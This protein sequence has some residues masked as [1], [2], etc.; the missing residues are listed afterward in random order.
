VSSTIPQPVVAQLTR[1]AIFLVVTIKPE[2]ECDHVVRALCSDL[3]ALLRAVGFRNIEGRLSCVMGFGSDAWDR[4]FEMPRP[5]ELHPFREIHGRHHAVATPGDIL[6]HIRSTR[7]D[8]CFELATQIMARLSG[9]VSTADEVHGFNYFDDRDLIGFVDGTENPVEQAAIDATIIDEEDAAFAGGSYVIVQKYLHDLKRWNQLPV[10]IQ[11]KI[12]GR[13]KLADIELDDAVKPTS[14]HNALT[15][16]V[17]N[18]KQLEIVR[19]NMPFG[20]V[21]KGEFGTYFIGYARSPHRIEQMLE[22]MFVGRPPG[23]YDRLLDFSRAVTGTLFFVPSATFLENVATGEAA[24][25]AADPTPNERKID[26]ASEPQM[27]SP[28]GSL[29]IGS[30]KGEAGHE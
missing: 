17:E 6:F 4:L 2:P 23:N 19:D 14:A 12:I 24:P 25:S 3:A 22:N 27:P 20:D 1:A 10:E 16:I 11:E 21:G 26:D 15:T 28:D 8:L 13:T 30:L 7:M 18:G 5:K 29:G 9:A